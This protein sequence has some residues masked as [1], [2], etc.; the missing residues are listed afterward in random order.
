MTLWED[1]GAEVDPLSALPALQFFADHAYSATAI[2]IDDRLAEN[3]E[4][5][6]G[7]CLEHFVEASELD[8]PLP[9]PPLDKDTIQ[10]PPNP[11]KWML[12]NDVLLGL[13]DLQIPSPD[14]VEAHYTRMA[15]LLTS[16]AS[17]PTHPLNARLALPAHLARVLSLKVTLRSKLQA[18]YRRGDV[19]ELTLILNERVRPLC[20][21]V[22]VLWRCHRRHWLDLCKPF[23]LEVL[24]GRYGTLRTRL[25][26]LEERLSDFLNHRVSCIPELEVDLQPCFGL[27]PT[28]GL[29]DYSRCTTA[30]YR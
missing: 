15:S 27:G 19:R 25:S 1:D 3:F 22:D 10:Q 21:E 12:W 6:C 7:G 5:T 29:F 24:E 18:A 23:G 20:R 8:Q 30:G 17:S 11:S 28:L 2:T 16:Y 14:T 9:A 13:L 4:G 26:S